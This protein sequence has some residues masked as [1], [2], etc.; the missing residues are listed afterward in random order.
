MKKNIFTGMPDPERPL[1]ILRLRSGHEK[2][3]VWERLFRQ[4]VEN[5]ACCDEVWFST[6]V[7]IPILEKHRKRSALMAEHAGEL[8]RHGIV[9]SLQ[10]QSTIGHSDDIIASAGADGKAWGSY[11]GVHGEQCKYINCPRQPGFLEYFRELSGIYAQWHPG[12]VWIDDD[13]RLYNHNPAPDPC[14]CYC[15]DCLAIFSREEGHDY[16]REELVKAC[17]NDPELYNRWKNFGERSLAQVIEVIVRAFRE[18]SPETRFGLQH[19]GSLSR[20][21]VSDALKKCANGK[22]G[23]RPG[24]GAYGDH[25]PYQMVEK[26]LHV[27]MQISTQPG[28]EYFSQIVPE[29]ESCPRCFTCKTSQGHR[30]ETMLYLAAGSDSM[31]YFIMD[32]A[33]ETPEWYGRE[34][35]KPLAE[36][37]P[38]YREFIRHNAGTLPGGIAAACRIGVCGISVI[39]IG[40]PLIGV[41]FAATSQANCGMMISCKA[42]ESFSENDLIEFFKSGCI[43]DGEAVMALQKRGLNHLIG[44]VRVYELKESASEYYTD[45]PLNAGFETRYH[46]PLRKIRFRFEAPEGMEYRTLG[47]YRDSK[48]RDCGIASLIF[49]APGGGRCALLG[50][51]GFDIHYVSSDRV[52]MLNRV[53][54]WIS[55]GRLPVMPVEPVQ[56]MFVPAV[57]E[58]ETLRSVT[59]LNPTIGH[60]KP[61]EVI[62]RGV[63]ESCKEIYWCVPAAD[64]VKL[65]F[66]MK[67]NEC[68]LTLPGI[69]P[70]DIG[71]L[72]ITC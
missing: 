20:L 68:R 38:C 41:P 14:G 10:I 51:N 36:E 42:A 70:W 37:A 62:L 49:T 66:S 59:V 31:S 46:S 9:P 7:G 61:F 58:N 55:G 43:L 72:K 34:L 26:M 71:W 63:P 54:D 28:Y 16:G 21:P 27:S 35:L 60:Q 32:P 22:I 67:G 29:I 3:S 25:A 11:V 19:G 12:S 15:K 4:L 40:L 50:Y 53:A 13:L 17:E 44:N 5:K 2:K 48:E 45:D 56:C 47:I 69:S 1:M 8:R 24:A 6:G 65:D 64:P 30:I 39:E 18:I 57:A 23:S 33:L 52:R